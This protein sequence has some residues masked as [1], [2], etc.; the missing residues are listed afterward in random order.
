MYNIKKLPGVLLIGLTSAIN[1]VGVCDGA[2]LAEADIISILLSLNG[3][4]LAWS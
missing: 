3:G 4:F 2:L 1:L